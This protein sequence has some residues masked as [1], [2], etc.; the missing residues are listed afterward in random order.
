MCVDWG[1]GKGA[2]G[3]PL[4]VAEPKGRQDKYFKWKQ[5]FCGLTKFKLLSQVK[6]R[7]VHDCDI[8]KYV[9]SVRG[10]HFHGLTQAWEA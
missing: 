6:R 7:S 2:S 8:S 10:G 4:Q 3:G 9:I 5:L 1:L